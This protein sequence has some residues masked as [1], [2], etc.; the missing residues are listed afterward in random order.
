MNCQNAKDL[1]PDHLDGLL[2]ESQDLALREH[3]AN[4][5]DCRRELA[6]LTRLLS[7][8][9]RSPE[10][11]PSPELRRNFNKML[12]TEIALAQGQSEAAHPSLFARLA[13]LWKSL[14]PRPTF[15]LA[16]SLALLLVGVMVGA[17]FLAPVSVDKTTP[18]ATQRELAELRGKIDS[19]GQLVAYSLTRQE[20]D[21]T[22]LRQVSASLDNDKLDN[23]QLGELVSALAFDPSINVRLTALDALYAYA[24]KAL[25]RESVIASLPRERS[26]L[27]QIRM[28]DFLASLREKQAGPAFEALSRDA[29]I[30]KNVREAA[31]Q[32]LTQ[33]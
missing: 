9:S 5:E 33:I 30:D 12:R 25:V 31:R 18:D 6:E 23:K 27:V 15:Q 8:I 21:N 10:E 17:R 1:M 19:M 2:S 29:S 7:T 28:I 4:C 32:A 16:Y 14:T 26:P 24:D 3:C 20:S 22:R 11:E 13:L